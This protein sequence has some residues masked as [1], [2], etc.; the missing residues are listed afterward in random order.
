MFALRRSVPQAPGFVGRG[1]LD[2]G[3]RGRLAGPVRFAS[4][5][6]R[7]LSQSSRNVTMPLS[8][9]GWWTICWSTLNGS[10]ATC[11]PA[12]AAW[13]MWSGLRI[14]AARTSV[15]RSWI[16]DDLDQLADDDHAVLVDVVEPADER[17]QQRCPGLGREEP[18]VGREDQRAVGLDALVGEAARSPRGPPRS[19]GTLT[20]MFGA[21]LA[22]AR[23]S[24]SMPSTSSATTSARHRAAA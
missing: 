16:V 22:K 9:S 12:S 17:R 19:S 10:V 14:D 4:S 15:S 2:L 11:A 5:A 7:A 18:L 20:T 21:S 23:P 13:V 1:L 24:V 6:F 8:V 3:L